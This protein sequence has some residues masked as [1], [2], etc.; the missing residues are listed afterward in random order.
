VARIGETKDVYRISI[1]K[2]LGKCPLGKDGK[3][4][5]IWILGLLVVR[6]KGG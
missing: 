5:L 6:I 4:T 2:P 1:A 3:I